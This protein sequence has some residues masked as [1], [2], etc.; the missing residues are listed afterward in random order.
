MTAISGI[1]LEYVPKYRDLEGL[2]HTRIHNKNSESILNG[3]YW[4]PDDC[5]VTLNNCQLGPPV[6]NE[7]FYNN[8]Q[9]NLICDQEIFELSDVS[10][11]NISS[12]DVQLEDIGS[13]GSFCGLNL[14]NNS[15]VQDSDVFKCNIKEGF[16]GLSTCIIPYGDTVITFVIYLIV[17][18]LVQISLSGS[19][20]VLTSKIMEEVEMHNGDYP[21]ILLY[22]SL[23]SAIG[24]LLA[25]NLVRRNSD[26][27][28]K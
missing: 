2:P 23:G 7:T 10:F 5:S 26:P 9:T 15:M 28:S 25:G 6:V 16:F 8:L 17:R 24:P 27:Y 11:Q 14:V 1:L 3:V 18:S 4:R 13:N 21:M 22:E 19:Y 20:I 12:M